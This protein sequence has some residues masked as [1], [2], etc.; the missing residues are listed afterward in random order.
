MVACVWFVET[1]SMN[2]ELSGMIFIFLH[3]FIKTYKG[4]SVVTALIGS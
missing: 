4:R 2:D 1:Y 3:F